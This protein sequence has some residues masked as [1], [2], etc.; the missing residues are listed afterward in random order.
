MPLTP[1]RYLRCGVGLLVLATLCGLLANATV[2]HVMDV[3]ALVESSDL[4]VSGSVS[5]VTEQG[6][7]TIN[8]ACGSLMGKKLL[9]VLLPDETIKGAAET[10]SLPVELGIPDSPCAISGVPSQQY[11]IFFLQREGPGYRFSDPTYPFLPAVRG[12]GSTTGPPLDRVVAKLGETLTYERSTEVEISSAIDALATI[13]RDSAT[14]TLRQALET[15]K[16]EV[17]LRIAWK[18]VAH[19]DMTGLDLVERALSHPA[20]LSDYW[21]LDLAGSLGGLKD[22]RAV[23]ALKRLLET[24]N[25]R[26]I[27]G[28]AIALRQ[29]ASADALEP[30][31][32]LLTNNDEQA[33]YYAVV[34]MGEITRQD[35][36]A[37]T[38]PE[39]REHEAKYVSYWRDW[40]ASNLAR[41]ASK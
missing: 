26:I 36:W 17:Q 22:P 11:G 41:H 38:F 1:N 33:R 40:A 12:G 32:R 3:A 19:N 29:S 35:E 7:G 15:T 5:S 10:A 25:Q 31:S 30:L 9:L 37:P 16:G 6:R 20:A 21:L 39:F 4:I 18:L 24:N 27:K 13:H 2:V 8:T 28:A 14:Q 34:G 23:P